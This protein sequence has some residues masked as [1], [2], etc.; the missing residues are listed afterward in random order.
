[1]QSKKLILE[2]FNA[3]ADEP[4]RSMSRL[5]DDIDQGSQNAVF[6]EFAQTGKTRPGFIN[7]SAR[8]HLDKG[9]HQD[10]QGPM[11]PPDQPLNTYGLYPVA[12]R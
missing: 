6:N 12:A 10:W 5:F 1:M 3:E 11:A 9:S 4:G 8:P 7:S 2:A